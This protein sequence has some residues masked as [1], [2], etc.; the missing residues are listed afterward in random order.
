V[1]PSRGGRAGRSVAL[2]LAVLVVLAAGWSLAGDRDPVPSVGDD[3]LAQLRAVVGELP[4]STLV[5]E[6]GATFA[7]LIAA[8]PETRRRGLQGVAEL[9][10]GVGMLFVDPAPAGVAGRPGFWMF[11]A[12]VPLDI[13][14]LTGDVLAGSG[15]VVA[16]A[17]MTPC[18]ALPCPVTHPG[19]DYDGALEV[20]AGELARGGITVGATVRWDV[21][22]G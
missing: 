15:R 12:L 2:V 9:P 7:V 14:F 6:G 17:T 5:T 20:A 1:R 21:P 22:Q 4:S 16:V 3:P 11:G 19:R 10:A 13:A 18:P 8:T